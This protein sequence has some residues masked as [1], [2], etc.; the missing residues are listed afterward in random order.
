[1]PTL[2]PGTPLIRDEWISQMSRHLIF[3]IPATGALVVVV[4]L[5]LRRTRKLYEEAKH[6]QVAEAA[7]KQSQ[8][9]EA[10]GQ[11]TGGVAHDFNNL[12]MVVRR[13]WPKTQANE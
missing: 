5:A 11:L 10:L 6:R 3:G 8:R 1:M 9:L 12:L 2:T 4:L 7:L 13:I